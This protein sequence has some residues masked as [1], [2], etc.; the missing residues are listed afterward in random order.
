MRAIA[1]ISKLFLF[2][3]IT[4]GAAWIGAYFTGWNVK[5]WYQNILLKPDWTPSGQLISGIW[6][7][8]FFL[9][10]LAMWLVSRRRNFK[11]YLIPLLIFLAQLFFNVLWSFLFFGIKSP[12]WALLDLSALLFMIGL[13]IMVFYPFSKF[14]A[15]LLVPYFGWVMFAGVLNLQIWRLN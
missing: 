3:A 1:D 13:T 2:L 11:D 14:S 4:F 5:D 9:M 6:T 15:V 10:A 7:L 12:G 8:L